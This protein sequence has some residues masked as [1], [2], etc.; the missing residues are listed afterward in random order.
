V[1]SLEYYILRYF[2]ICAGRILLS[3]Y[4]GLVVELGWGDRIVIQNFSAETSWEVPT[5]KT[6]K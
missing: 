4:K 3:G 5:W 2:V 1:G 6:E